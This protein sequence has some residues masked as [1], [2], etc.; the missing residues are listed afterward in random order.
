LRFFEKNGS[1]A[2]PLAKAQGGLLQG[3]GGRGAPLQQRRSLWAVV[4]SCAGVVCPFLLC[5]AVKPQA[6]QLL[7][8]AQ[9]A[10]G[11]CKGVSLTTTQGALVCCKE[12]RWHFGSATRGR[13]KLRPRNG[14]QPQ[15][16]V[17]HR[18]TPPWRRS[19]QQPRAIWAGCKE[20]PRALPKFLWFS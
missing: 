3:K 17:S 14:K 7:T 12:M 11:C 8:P 20:H 6:A 2:T 16:C 18:S 9:S 10:L 4:W 5:F 1:T 13:A 19:L 15:M